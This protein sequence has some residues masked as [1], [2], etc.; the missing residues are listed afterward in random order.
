M[1]DYTVAT[2]ILNQLGGKHFMLMTG[3]QVVKTTENSIEVSVGRNAAK[4][5][6]FAVTLRGDDTYNIDFVYQS[7]N[8]KTFSITRKTIKHLEMIYAD[9]LQDIF[10]ETTGMSL[11][12]LRVQWQ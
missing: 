1:T 11:A 2:E 3:A 9:Q 7:M 10:E 12:T 8:H 5:N 4:I 6:R